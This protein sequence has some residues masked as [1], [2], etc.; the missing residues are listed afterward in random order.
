MNDLA[1]PI[2]TQGVLGVAVVALSFVVAKLYS[3]LERLEKEKADILEAWRLE[4]KTD[5]KDALEV[6]KGNSQNM[7]YLAEKIESAKKVGG[8]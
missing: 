3:K 8:V 2:L 6:L 7:F 5:G 1:T 4:T